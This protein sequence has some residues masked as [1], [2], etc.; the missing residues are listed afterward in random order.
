MQVW[1]GLNGTEDVSYTYDTSALRDTPQGYGLTVGA[2]SPHG[3]EGAQITGAPTGDY[4]VTSTPGAP[5]GS[6]NVSLTVKATDTGNGTVTSSLTADTVP[7]TTIVSS[8][9]QIRRS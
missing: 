3:T 1:I 2:E 7:G 8:S 4:V 6:I 9:I 5:G